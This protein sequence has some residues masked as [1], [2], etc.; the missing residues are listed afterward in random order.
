MGN[1]LRKTRRKT[2]HRTHRAEICDN[3][4]SHQMNRPIENI[5]GP[6]RTQESSE[7]VSD[8]ERHIEDT[9]KLHQVLE[10][11]THVV[12]TYMEELVDRIG[13][14]VEAH[15]R[16]YDAQKAEILQQQQQVDEA[17][18]TDLKNTLLQ[19]HIKSNS[20]LSLGPFFR[21][22]DSRLEDFFIPPR[23]FEV[24]QK[25]KVDTENRATENQK[26]PITSL[27][28]L[29]T[30]ND[31]TKKITIITANAGV[32]KTS[33]C[34]FVAVLWC[35]LHDDQTDTISKFKERFDIPFASLKDIPYLLYIPMRDI[36][37]NRTHSIED[38]VFAHLEKEIGYQKQDREK[39]ERVFTDERCLVIL[40]G[41]DETS[42][43]TLNSPMANR[44]YS[45][46][47]T[48]RPWKLAD[49]ALPKYMHVSIDDL[50]QNFQKQ[51]FE[52]VNQ[53]L[54]IFYGTK[55]EVE[56]FFAT[57]QTL[58]L[59]SL[60]SN[61][62]VGLQ[63]YCVWQDR[64]M[65]DETPKNNK[66]SVT[67]G[68]TRS[69]I[70]ADI[71]EMMFSLV[72][73]KSKDSSER[74]HT[75]PPAQRPLPKCFEGRKLCKAKSSLIYETGKVAFEMLIN[76]KNNF[77][78][79]TMNSLQ[80]KQFLLHSGLISADRSHKCSIEIKEYRFLHKT[81]QEMLAALFISSLDFKSEDWLAFEN[82]F[83]TAFSPDLM[84]FLCVMNYEHG[85]RCSEMFGDT[86][87]EFYRGYT[88]YKN[89]IIEYQDA[90]L[91]SYNECVN[92]GVSNPQLTFRH[93]HL[94]RENNA[95]YYPLLQHSR[96]GL[97]SCIIE[98]SEEYPVII[99]M[100]GMEQLNTLCIF[101]EN[102][103]DAYP[104]TIPTCSLNKLTVLCLFNFYIENDNLHLSS[105]E[106][107]TIL[108]LNNVHLDHVTIAPAQLEE[109]WV[110]I[111]D[112]ML[113]KTPPM[114]VT[115]ARGEQFTEKLRELS[116]VNV[117]FNET[118]NIRQCDKLQK[119]QLGTLT[120]PDDFHLDL[121]SFTDL[122]DVTLQN[123]R[124][125]H[126]TIAPAQVEEFW[127][128]IKADMLEKTP[129]ME[130]TFAH[131]EQFTDKLRKLSLINVT[132]NETLNIRQ[133]DKLQKLKLDTLTFPDDF[134]LDLSSFTDLTK[135]TLLDLR[136]HHVTIAPAQ[137][138]EFWV[139]IM[140]DMLE[141]TPPM[142]VT[143][144][145]G[146][147]FTEKLRVLS[148]KN[149]TFNETLNIRQCDK[150]Q[151]LKLDT[152]TFPDDFHLDLSSFTDL[153]EVTLHNL[154]LHHVTIAPAQLEVF[155][156]KINN[157]MRKKTP[158]MEV[159]FAQGEQF[160]E[161][162]RKL[163]LINVT[164]N[165]TL[166][167][168]QCDKLQKLQ[169]DTLTFPDDFHLDLS[170]CTDLTEVTL[171]NLR[172]HHVTIAP[173][174][175]E[176]FCV[177]IKDDMLENTPPMEV[178][179]ARGEQ[180]TEKLRELSLDNVTLNEILNLRQCHKLQ[181]LHL[182]TLTFPD[183][184]HLDLSS[185]TDLTEVTLWN[186]R[187]HHVTIAPAQVE[188]FWVY[189]KDDMLEKTP[190]MEVTF[191]RGEQF[192]EKLRKLGLHNVTFNET[193]NIRQCDKL[194]ILKL[195]TL[196]F[197]DDFHLDLSSFTDLTEVTLE[198]LRLHHV[199]IAPAQ[200][201]V[202]FVKINNQMRK[203]TPPMEVTFAQGEQ[204]TEKLRMLCLVH[205]T[206]NETLNIR[207][208]GKLQKLQLA[209]LT[210][211]DDFHLDLSSCTDLAEIYFFNLRLMHM[212][213]AP[214]QLEVF[215]VSI[216][217]QMRK[218]T[219]PMEVTFANGEHFTK[220]LRKQRMDNV[221]LKTTLDIPE[222]DK[223]HNLRRTTCK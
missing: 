114:E 208:C 95:A 99:S 5:Q 101:S 217:N 124:L 109:F 102:E 7:L 2:D 67:L 198:N 171:W 77:N 13:E 28:Q 17:F 112:D 8:I 152:L 73:N 91:L 80:D 61:T 97:K 52:H 158:P 216:N 89:E 210:F 166:N 159:T 51:L 149:V 221:T 83:N 32:G 164:F 142:E 42:L 86:K 75:P 105:C 25:I 134:H 100:T 150:L 222:R 203:K 119:L 154:R 140:G 15:K 50:S 111:K 190:P 146:E 196:T 157:Q 147:Q 43:S 156:V 174:Q 199:T 120:F 24:L 113:E 136:L 9:T 167:I 194:Q 14:D 3:V 55:F 104:Q 34:K 137:L 108:V 192:T 180:F 181:K 178:T 202:F 21:H 41:M 145:R 170:S 65:D 138:E 223:Q 58:K 19:H 6:I 201:E 4:R 96:N 173:A 183:D 165:E 81:Y 76:S 59:Q 12:A 163:T 47:I 33:F 88:C 27:E 139:Y 44:K 84:S 79:A 179:F 160:T 85:R 186:L 94:D 116:L 151:K 128:Y 118:L 177:Y 98:C 107:L 220:K 106:N 215:S 93:A 121:S 117:T 56:D 162:L 182:D 11:K 63:L 87:R 185:F 197:P 189:I 155:F 18:K 48:C 71:L 129:P 103:N 219:P 69:H 20:T 68:P 53:I 191:A 213:I 40:D 130:V 214:A 205:V 169:L 92:N 54:N 200:L 133:C 1:Y 188:K 110:Y 10:N 148:L 66:T 153:T 60:S 135:V 22:G 29:L 175:L 122:I 26:S 39:L 127:V 31:K 49:M 207:Q 70:Y 209:T 212:T 206:L 37:P 132:F 36:P 161:K 218:K 176:E 172:L 193:L 131:G 90:V 16:D 195:D 123:L 72:N 141:K 57:L 125:H 35:A 46:I 143:F 204:F 126:V 62:L 45:I 187:L 168:R 78:E 115:F 184:F 64:R 82:N 38:I 23:L 30:P 74:P 211:P 144:A